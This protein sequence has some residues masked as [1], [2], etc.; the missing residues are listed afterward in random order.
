MD[1][2]CS[3]H[4]WLVLVVC[5][6]LYTCASIDLALTL[7][8]ARP[9]AELSDEEKEAVETELDAARGKGLKGFEEALTFWAPDGSG[10]VLSWAEF[11]QAAAGA[12]RE[13]GGLPHPKACLFEFTCAG[14]VVR[15]PNTYTDIHVQELLRQLEEENARW[16]AK[17]GQQRPA[18][19][20]ANSR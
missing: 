20:G 12:G 5:L 14:L 19:V 18:G 15:G 3:R 17:G 4:V 2:V 1:S 6:W 16:A 7:L 10:K 11:Q 9:Q 13:E 8:Y